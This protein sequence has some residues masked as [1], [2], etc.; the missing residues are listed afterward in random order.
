MFDEVE[1]LIRRRLVLFSTEDHFV[2]YYD[3]RGEAPSFSDVEESRSFHD[4]S[5]PEGFVLHRHTAC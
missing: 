1:C 5:L 3:R 4:H 2:P